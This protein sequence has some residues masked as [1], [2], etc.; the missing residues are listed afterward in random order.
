MKSGVR[1]DE[2]RRAVARMKEADV[3]RKYEQGASPVK[4]KQPKVEIWASLLNEARDKGYLEL[5][6]Q[7]PK[8]KGER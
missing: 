6:D 3:L 5:M 1:K 4:T 7:W 2:M 8:R